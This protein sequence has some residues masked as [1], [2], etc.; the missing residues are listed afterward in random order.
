M[1][2]NLQV[3]LTIPIADPVENGW[4]KPRFGLSIIFGMPK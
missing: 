2:D 3:I 1:I 4:E